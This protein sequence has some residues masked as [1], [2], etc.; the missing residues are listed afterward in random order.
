MS[1]EEIKTARMNLK[2]VKGILKRCNGLSDSQKAYYEVRLGDI[3]TRINNGED[4]VLITSELKKLKHDFVSFTF[5][6]DGTASLPTL[7]HREQMDRTRQIIQCRDKHR[8]SHNRARLACEFND[9]TAEEKEAAINEFN[10]SRNIVCKVPQNPDF[11]SHVTLYIEEPEIEKILAIHRKNVHVKTQRI[12]KKK[13]QKESEAEKK[14]A[15][16]GFVIEFDF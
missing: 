4:P 10:K 7:E 11:T 5:T 3:N 13:K 14:K 12:E 8:I 2:H 15:A 1:I 6:N 16:Q 9:L